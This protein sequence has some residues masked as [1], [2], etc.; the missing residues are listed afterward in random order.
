MIKA[1]LKKTLMKP[2]FL[3]PLFNL[4]AP[5]RGAGI[6]IREIDPA[7]QFIV[8][9]MPLTRRNKNIVGTHFGGSL[10]AMADP[11]Y[12]FILMQ[13]LGSKY[14]VWDQDA[15]IRFVSPG[16]G[17][18][19]GVFEVNDSALDDIRQQASSGK[20]VLYTFQTEIK[21]LDGS[22][23]AEVSKTLYIRLRPEHR[24][25]AAS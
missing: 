13:R 11:F 8:V 23:V 20:K 3:R 5:F 18:V 14:L 15:S 17:L 22:V 10:Y 7:Y 9:D 4:Y 25:Q 19:R 24:P 16:K 1:A 6:Q 21:H 2:Q 12:M